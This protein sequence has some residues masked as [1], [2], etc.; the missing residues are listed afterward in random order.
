[1]IG[2]ENNGGIPNLGAWPAL[3]R[4]CSFYILGADR[5]EIPTA[6]SRA[7]GGWVRGS[8]KRRGEIKWVTG[9]AHTLSCMYAPF[10]LPRPSEAHT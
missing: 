8:I 9:V 4:V 3:E 5:V 6:V 10:L 1:M 2:G 7:G